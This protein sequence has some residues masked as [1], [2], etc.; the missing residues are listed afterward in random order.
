MEVKSVSDDD[1]DDDDDGASKNTGREGGGNEGLRL[2]EKNKK[3]KS[4]G[5]RSPSPAAV[6]AA[7]REMHA[8]SAEWER[9]ERNEQQT[10]QRL[11]QSEKPLRSAGERAFFAALRH[12]L[13]ECMEAETEVEQRRRAIATFRWYIGRIEGNSALNLAGDASPPDGRDDEESHG[14]VR[15]PRG[16]GKSAQLFPLCAFPSVARLDESRRGLRGIASR[17]KKAPGRRDRRKRHSRRA[18]A[19][20]NDSIDAIERLGAI[21]LP[22]ETTC[23]ISLYVALALS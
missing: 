6:N 15:K 8:A 7:L 10:Q 4:N 14:I 5:M 18:V 16:G 1:D 17:E 22:H 3:N 23:C 19:E 9:Q 12:H 11:R 13:E 2:R 21:I 20:E